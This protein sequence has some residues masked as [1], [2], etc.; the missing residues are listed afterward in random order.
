MWDCSVQERE[1]DGH[2]R[3]AQGEVDDL[4]DPA[5]ELEPA[6]KIRGRGGNDRVHYERREDEQAETDDNNQE[7]VQPVASRC[8]NRRQDACFRRWQVT[9]HPP[10]HV[11]RVSK[12]ADQCRRAE[13]A[14][15]PRPL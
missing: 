10:D 8:S 15:A 12:L 11:Q 2:Q 1:H 7:L 14:P 6:L 5:A 4:Q 13:R 9:L 3:E